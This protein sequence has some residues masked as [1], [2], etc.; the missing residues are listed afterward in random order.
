[1]ALDSDDAVVEALL[2]LKRR[3]KTGL[4]RDE[5]AQLWL[6]CCRAVAQRL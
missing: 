1:M 6:L 5:Y 3:Y 4:V 2:Q